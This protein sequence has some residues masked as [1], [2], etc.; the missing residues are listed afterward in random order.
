M[1]EDL[2]DGVKRRA[3][4]ERRAYILP[5]PPPKLCSV[6][7]VGERRPKICGAAL[8]GVIEPRLMAIKAA[9]AGWT[10]KR[11][12]NIPSGRAAKLSHPRAKISAIKLIGAPHRLVDQPIYEPRFGA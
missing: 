3:D 11:K 1:F 6:G 7:V 8:P 12:P 5:S 2:V 9:T 4:K 10:K